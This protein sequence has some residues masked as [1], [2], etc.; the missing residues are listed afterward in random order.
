MHF[1]GGVSETKGLRTAGRCRV[2]SEGR[3]WVMRKQVEA[4]SSGPGGSREEAVRAPPDEMGKRALEEDDRRRGDRDGWIGCRTNRH[5]A[6][7]DYFESRK[8][9]LGLRKN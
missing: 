4:W 8:A 6:L 1:A 9:D 5:S 7:L 3:G 2:G